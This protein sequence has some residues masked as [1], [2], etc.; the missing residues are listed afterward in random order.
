MVKLTIAYKDS[1][2]NFHGIY[3]DIKRSNESIQN[4][5]ILKNNNYIFICTNES[6]LQLLSNMESLSKKAWY[7]VSLM[8]K[9]NFKIE[10]IKNQITQLFQRLKTFFKSELDL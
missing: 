9:G 8:K 1:N 6:D 3:E 10:D 7:K 2:D 4:N 5:S